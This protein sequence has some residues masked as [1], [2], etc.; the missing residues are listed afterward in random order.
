MAPNAL[1]HSD[2]QP[3]RRAAE[4]T[5]WRAGAPAMPEAGISVVSPAVPLVGDPLAGLD[6]LDEVAER[7]R[8][9]YCCGLCPARKN[10]VPG[11]GSAT[12]KL[13]LVGE[14]PGATEDE[15]GRPFVG[16]AGKLLDDILAA[17][18]LRVVHEEPSVFGGVFRV[19]IA[20]RAAS[21]VR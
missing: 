20:E 14:G 18:D 19:A 16:Q 5:N 7:V 21:G 13:V 9:T 1:P 17:T 10:A 15:T 6:T 8:S 2:A 11:E 4:P 12:A 3:S